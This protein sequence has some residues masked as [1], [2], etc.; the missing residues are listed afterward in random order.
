MTTKT[1]VWKSTRNTR[2]IKDTKNC[3]L[4][5]MLITKQTVA[6][7]IAA[8]LHHEITLAQ[9][10]DWAEDAIM[11]G[12]FADGEMDALR[13]VVSRLG[14]ADVRAFGLAWEDC[15]HLLEQLGY[16]ARVDVVAA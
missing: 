7:K 3:N 14:V 15:E 10:V 8:Y 1:G 11:D 9:L 6:G 2:W 13:L 4:Q 5:P 12:E 16:S